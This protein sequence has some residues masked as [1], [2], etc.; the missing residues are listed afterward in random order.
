MIP[1]PAMPSSFKATGRAVKTRALWHGSMG[2]DDFVRI[3]L[4]E[5][6]ERVQLV[7]EGVPARVVVAISD[8]MAI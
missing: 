5:P 1:K 4:F 3:Y 7:K 8:S 2:A 6:N